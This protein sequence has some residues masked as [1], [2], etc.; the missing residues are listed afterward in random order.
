VAAD[1]S[2]ALRRQRWRDALLIG[3]G[4]AALALVIV[5]QAWA[6]RFDRLLYDLGLAQ[7][8]RSAAADIVIVAID[9][10][11][12]AAIGRWPWR[13]AV[14]TTLLEKLAVARPRAVM[15]D[16]VLSEADPDPR[17]DVLLAQALRAAAPVVV[18]VAWIAVPGQAPRLLEPAGPLRDA[19]PWVQA[20]VEPDSD[21]ILRHTFLRAGLGRA[22]LPHAALALL[23][24]GGEPLKALPPTEDAPPARGGLAD[25]WV[26]DARMP[27]RYQGPAGLLQRVSY[28]DAQGTKGPCAEHVKPK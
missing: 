22:D 26:R 13:R 4:L 20:D 6:W 10:A 24:A 15:L 21:G 18:P 7:A 28:V 25:T 9:D 2:R 17:Q 8:P 12:V 16:L 19:A 14:H 3:G 27:I 23:Q 1:D 11:S 5:M